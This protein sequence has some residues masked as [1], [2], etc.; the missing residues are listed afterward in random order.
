LGARTA[1]M[2]EPYSD[3]SEESGTLVFDEAFIRRR[4][5]LAR[6]KGMD[7]AMHAIGDRTIETLIRVNETRREEG[8]RDA[9]I[10]AQLADHEQV[11]RMREVGLGAQVQPAFIASDA[12]IVKDRLGK[13]SETTYLFNTMIQKGVPTAFSTDA[14]IED[15]NPFSTLYTAITRKTEEGRETFNDDERVPFHDALAAYT[16]TPAYFMRM[17]DR[18][19]AL[20]KGHLADFIVVKA[21]D[22]N[23]VETLREA[24]VLETY[25]EGECVFSDRSFSKQKMDPKLS[26]EAYVL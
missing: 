11:E 3:A 20:K 17:E 14:P 25:I 6:K 19:G 15:V 13:R 10:H 7:Y 18:L 22:F 26:K 5:D 16:K 8:Y 1:A 12:P 21:L 24:K 4:L 2:R 9:I 23:N